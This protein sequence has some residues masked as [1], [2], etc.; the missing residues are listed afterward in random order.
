MNALKTHAAL[1]ATLLAACLAGNALAQEAE[2]DAWQKLPQPQSRAALATPKGNTRAEVRAE[3]L[4]AR[5]CGEL[6]AINAQA[7]AFEPAGPAPPLMAQR[8]R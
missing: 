7:C 4:E 5:R 2:S 1:L 8:P 6:A 3:L